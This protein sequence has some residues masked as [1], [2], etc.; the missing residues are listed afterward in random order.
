MIV[1]VVIFPVGTVQAMR[2]SESGPDILVVSIERPQDI[3][4]RA[5]TNVWMTTS[6][7]GCKIQSVSVTNIIR[8]I[9]T[10][11]DR[12][13]VIGRWLHNMI[14]GIVLR[15]GQSPALAYRGML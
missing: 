14:D 11:K 5:I 1:E 8:G 15:R 7:V 10:T 12:T 3:V 9:N 2:F 13:M 4:G 6:S